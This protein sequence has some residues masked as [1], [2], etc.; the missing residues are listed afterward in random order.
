MNFHIITVPSLPST[1]SALKDWAAGVGEWGARGPLAPC[2]VLR[3]DS[4][5][6]G[7]GR[8]GRLFVSPAG[9]LYMSVFLPAQAVS[10]PEELTCR[11]CAAVCLAV[12]E[13]AN[14]ALSI[15]WVNDLYL[16][17][18]KICGILCEGIA[19]GYICGIGINLNT[20]QGGFPPEAGPAGALDR[21]GLTADGLM[22]HIL[23]L[24]PRALENDFGPEA[25]QLY[26]SRDY[27]CGK[28]LVWQRGDSLIPCRA[29]GIDEDFSLLARAGDGRILRIRA[30]ETLLRKDL[31]T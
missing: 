13:A 24:L 1:N 31:L 12:E 20:P 10:A 25:L 30:G 16:D 21:P 8:K 7:R 26:R 18:R 11:I 19:Q 29:E 15:K 2:T 9:G 28:D 5:T 27:L 6:G 23:R 14:A 4:Q 22:R 17:G 3:A